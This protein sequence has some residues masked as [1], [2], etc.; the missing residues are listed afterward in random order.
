MLIKLPE[1]VFPKLQKSCSKA[2]FFFFF[3]FCC[4]S[5]AASYNV[6]TKACI[7]LRKINFFSLEKMLRAFIPPYCPPQSPSVQFFEVIF[8][9]ASVAFTQLQS[10]G[11]QL[12]L[13]RWMLF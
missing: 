2:C 5:V 9:D 6:K 12:F 8:G 10:P 3:A 1:L 4:H 7:T 11:V 13:K